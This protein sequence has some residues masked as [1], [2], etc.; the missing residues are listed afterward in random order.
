MRLIAIPAAK[1]RALL[2]I[3][4]L[5]ANELPTGDR[6]IDQLWGGRP[7]ASARKVLQTYVSKIRRWWAIGIGERV[8]RV[9][10]L[11][12]EPGQLGLLASVSGSRAE[13]GKCA[14]PC[15]GPA[16]VGACCRAPG[17]WSPSTRR[18][19]RRLNG[20]GPST[21]SLP[22]M[23]LRWDRRLMR[24]ELGCPSRPGRPRTDDVVA[25]LVDEDGRAE[26]VGRGQRQ[27]VGLALVALLR[28]PARLAE[29]K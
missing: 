21:G 12:V 3:L 10:E 2:A 7:P 28:S 14:E 29:V 20:R 11:R 16:H 13:G 5:G 23:I 9:I 8:L 6:L 18:Y 27:P 1:Q 4:L 24:P 17:R 15:V 19:A 22:G 25:A 26:V